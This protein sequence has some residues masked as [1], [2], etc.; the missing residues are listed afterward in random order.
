MQDGNIVDTF[1]P[2]TADIK[3]STSNQSTGWYSTLNSGYYVVGII[4]RSSSASAGVVTYY[5]MSTAQLST[6]R[7]ALMGN[8]DWLGSVTDISTQ[9]L[10]AQF[11]PLQYIVSCKWF[12]FAPPTGSS[13]DSISYGWWNLEGVSASLLANTPIHTDA[14]SITLPKHPNSNSRG[15]YLNLH[16]YSTYNLEFRP[17]GFF[18][19]DTTYLTETNNVYMQTRTDCLT[20]ISTLTISPDTGYKDTLITSQCNLGVDIQLA[21][22][23]SDYLGAATSA[24]G[25]VESIATGN[26]TGALSS[27]ASA[28]NSIIPQVQKFNTNGGVSD[29]S[30]GI[31]L[32]ARFMIPVSDY[33]GKMGRPYCKPIK[34]DDITGYILCENASISSIA[35]KNEAD[36]IIEY[37]N[38]GF[39]YE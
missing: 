13:V 10:K 30:Y 28:A 9:L 24:V 3:L 34:I 6:L 18:A 7:N 27:I 12:P 35:T 14:F 17:F 11:N 1:F 38:G 22:M 26:I 25:A 36:A 37:L 21:Q 29:F 33:N 19:L 39:Y 5:V 15:R 4:N 32:Y 20:G 23:S 2:A 8:V 16:P 31:H